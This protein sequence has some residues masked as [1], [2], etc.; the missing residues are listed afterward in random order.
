MSGKLDL[1]KIAQEEA[2]GDLF[3]YLDG[4][5]KRSKTQPRGISDAIIWEGGNFTG[6]V[7]PVAHAL[8]D[9]FALNG[10]IMALDVSPV[11]APRV[12]GSRHRTANG[13]A[14]PVE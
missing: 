3:K 1:L 4:I 13:P 10:T 12:G 7:N 11:P 14:R 8:T 9:T 2:S 6:G 5:F